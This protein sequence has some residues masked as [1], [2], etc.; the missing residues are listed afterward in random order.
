MKNL[1]KILMIAFLLSGCSSKGENKFSHSYVKTHIIENKTT[2]AEVQAI[3]GTP[4]DQNI[5]EVSVTWIYEK[6]GNLGTVSSLVGYIPGAGAV[7]SA[8]GM[9]NTANDIA[10]DTKKVSGKMTGDTNY[11]GDILFV[12]FNNKKIVTSWTID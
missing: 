6:N 11:H 3:Y 12:R 1:I 5:D 9:A 8:L 2:Q 7:S 4:D 10:D